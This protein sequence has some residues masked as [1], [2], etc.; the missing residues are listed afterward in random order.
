MKKVLLAAGVASLVVF[1]SIGC[2]STCCSKPSTSNCATGQ[3]APGTPGAP[4]V[5]GMSPATM[6][7]TP[8]T[9]QTMPGK[10]AMMPTSPTTS[11]PA[12]PMLLPQQ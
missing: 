1:G 2:S 8:T 11:G 12:N 4:V 3:C 7:G 9:V 6:P 10:P 5:T